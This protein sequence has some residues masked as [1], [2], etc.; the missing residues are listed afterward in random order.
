MNEEKQTQTNNFKDV[1]EYP[2]FPDSEKQNP[3]LIY[4]RELVN[5]APRECDIW[6]LDGEQSPEYF[7][8]YLSDCIYCAISVSKS[9]MK[10]NLPKYLYKQ[11][12]E[13]IKNLED[14]KI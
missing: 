4:I 2:K 14:L 3:A 5:G 8:R 6:L 13:I 10:K 12:K 9:W 11:I 1:C 7:E